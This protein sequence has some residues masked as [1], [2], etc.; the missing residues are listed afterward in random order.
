[1]A[2]TS[3]CFILG[4]NCSFSSDCKE[5][6]VNNNILVCGGT[7]SGKTFSIVEPFLLGVQSM[8]IILSLTKRRLIDKY[9]SYLRTKGYTVWDLN[10]VNPE[11]GDIGFNLLQYVRTP[12]DATFLAKA[13]V[14][15]DKRKENSHADPYWDQCAISLLCAFIGAA[16]TIKS[17]ANMKDVLDLFGK[18]SVGDGTGLID[19]NYDDWFENISDKDEQWARYTYTCWKSFRILPIKTAGCV[20]SALN[21]TLDNIFTPSIRKL[22]CTSRNVDFHRFVTRRLALMITSSPVNPSL[23]ALVNI[24][25]SFAFKELFEVAENLPDGMLPIPVHVIA[26]DFATG[27]KIENFPEY[28]SIF[29]EKQISC[30]LLLQSETQLQS[31]YGEYD[32]TTIINNCDTYVYMGSN[33]L[34]TARNVSVRVN[35]PLEDILYMPVGHEIVF[36]RGMRPISTTRYDILHDAKYLA[37]MENKKAK[38]EETKGKTSDK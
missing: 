10:F 23:N 26:D 4:N 35:R 34:V 6:L 24:F 9:K 1:M 14:M 20:F 33:D 28:I 19:T 36:R 25:Y 27:G 22:F 15:A 12:S 38:Q 30:S 31:M 37:L 21:V 8:N 5:T 32:S 13:I 29:R 17:S 7:G 3:D 18:L 2:K 16:K 11:R